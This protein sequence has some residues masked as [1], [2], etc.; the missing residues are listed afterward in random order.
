VRWL[1]IGNIS[2]TISVTSDP[3]DRGRDGSGNVGNFN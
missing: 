1:K 3:E 2:M